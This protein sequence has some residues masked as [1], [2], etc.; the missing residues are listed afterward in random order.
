MNHC[1]KKEA[2]LGLRGGNL[3]VE[4]AILRMESATG[5]GDITFLNL[6]SKRSGLSIEKSEMDLRGSASPGCANRLDP[7]YMAGAQ[8]RAGVR[9]VF[10]VI[11]ALDRPMRRYLC[12]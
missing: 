6:W 5:E 10:F 9:M 3:G 7:P 8:E 1:P 4:I 12:P 11:I 2:D